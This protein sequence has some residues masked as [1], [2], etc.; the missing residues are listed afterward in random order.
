MAAN[1]GAKDSR[2]GALTGLWKSRPRSSALVR[3]AL[4]LMVSSMG[5]ALLGVAFWGVAAHLASVEV[6][7]KSSAELSAM[8]LLAGLASL[9]LGVTFVRFLPV[10]GNRTRQFVGRAYGTCTSLAAV[11]AVAY[12]LS[13]LGRRFLP[14]AMGW[15]V[16]FVAV[17][18]LWTVFVLQD[19]VL[20]GLRSTK[21]VPV[22]NI[23]FGLTK[24]ALLPLALLL[25]RNEGIVF[26]WSVPV[27]VAVIAVSRFL[28][29]KRIPQHEAASGGRNILPS[30]REFVSI[31][32][33][34][35]T[36]GLVGVLAS[37]VM[38]L[39]VIARL[40]AAANGH[41]YLPWTII[42]AFNQ[43]VSN[44]GTSF[45]V[46][47][48]HDATA[49]RRH[50]DRTLRL[51]LVV[52]LPG[53]AI[54]IVFAPNL[55]RIFGETYA[56]HGTTLLRLLFCSMPG[57]AI[58]S[59][60]I[61][62]A[63]IEQRMWLLAVR[64]FGCAVVFLGATFLFIGHFGVLAI[65]IASLATEALEAIVF[66]A[67]SIARYRSVHRGDAARAGTTAENRIQMI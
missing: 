33:A 4:A 16:F 49:M 20:T 14:S 43:L 62:F 21:W 58:A 67:P 63:W 64:Q 42:V 5:T 53:I 17:V 24:L 29:G 52:L 32:S 51:A 8:S 61:S 3:N 34:Q 48:A 25:F 2:L 11:L 55:L 35:F 40:G 50:M 41:F 46:E 1:S 30:R 6:I 47:V 12:I 18:V 19:A 22:E 45:V 44:V 60:Y 37:T 23:L 39:I 66:L 59:F 57:T 28:F 26:A 15:R 54:G 65:G 7:G 13:G 56:V 27:F 36:T 10:A 38:P 9:S 31:L